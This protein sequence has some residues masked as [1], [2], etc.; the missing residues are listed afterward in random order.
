MVEWL[1]R[2]NESWL[3]SARRMSPR[4]LCEL[5]A[6]TGEAVFHYFSS[7]DP[8]DIGGPVS[9]AGPDPAPVWLDIAR[10]YTERWVHQQQIRDAVGRSGLKEPRFLGPVLDT[11]VRALPYTF[12]NVDAGSGTS[13]GLHISGDSG[14]KWMVVKEREG[15]RLYRADDTRQSA[16]VTLDQ[17]IAWRLFTKGL[18]REEAM[19]VAD[20]EGDRA[21]AVTV[22]DT[23]SIIA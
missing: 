5:L 4:L 1:N 12:R 8:Y 18:G 14:G 10:E 2:W 22:F 19:R 11:F 7:L 6:T 3:E 21:L 16:N 23:V 13:V 9:W 20:I 15:W 17:D